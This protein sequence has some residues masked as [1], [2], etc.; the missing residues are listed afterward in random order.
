MR[1]LIM[2]FLLLTGLALALEPAPNPDK[3]ASVE[4]ALTYLSPPFPM[5]KALKEALSGRKHSEAATLLAAVDKSKIPG[6]AVGDHGFLMAW[7]LLRAGKA[8]EA[9]KYTA[10]VEKAEHAPP[11]YKALTLAELYSA[12]GR[13]VE[14]AKALETFPADA[15]LWP[16]A[17]LARASALRYAGNTA[18]SRALYEQL[19]ARPDPSEG[20][21]WALLNLAQQAGKGSPAAYPLYRRIWAYYPTTEAGKQAETALKEYPT[22]ATWQESAVRGDRLMVANNFQGAVTLLQPLLPKV[23]AP[24]AD[25]CRLWYAYGRSLFKLNRLT[26]AADVLGP[27]GVKCKGFDDDRGAK[28]LYIAGKAQERKKAW[29]EAARLFAEIPKLYPT[30]SYADDGY[31]L[32]GIGLQEAGDPEAARTLW[33]EGVKKV[34][35]GDLAAES[36]WRLA[37]GAY[38]AGKTD[39]AIQWAEKGAWEVPITADATHVQACLYWAARWRAWPD[40]NAPHTLTTDPKRKEEAARLLQRFVEQHP[41]NWYT[42]LAAARLKELDPGA[43]AKLPDPPKGK[44]TPWVVREEFLKDPHIAAGLALAQLGLTREALAEL[45]RLDEGA[46]TPAEF[47]LIT[48]IQWDQGDI[49]FAHERLRSYIDTHPPEVMGAQR[50]RV[51]VQAYPE[52]YWDEVK[53]AAKEYGW[54][55]RM[56]HALVREE[57]SFN[58]EIV[59]H[60]GARGLSQLMPATARTVAGWLSM[61]VT[62]A[63]L[64]DP[65]INTKIGARYMQF[66]MLRYGG[67]PALSMAGYNAG[68]GNVDKWLREKGNLPTDEFVESI[69]FRETRGYVKRVSRTWVTYHHLYDDGPVL[70]DLSAYNHKAKP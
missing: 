65:A 51:L 27:A 12:D 63:Q 23:T 6:H 47:A 30:H 18:A 28:A 44:K 41:H 70:P 43:W 20:S 13:H 62:T 42:L 46:Y 21:E 67:N 68:E 5:D 11:T 1:R 16:R 7:S 48:S 8:S 34:P 10:M 26:E 61:S 25:A 59:S 57:S 45:T 24:S 36:F 37:W 15:Q 49:L 66:L 9:V 17:M 2:P 32:G 54:D 56:F 55:P 35:D 33:A 69:P 29:A 19:A 31:A 3:P 50:D 22:A 60:A 64:N 52:L 40:V 53:A 58:K 38:R 14:A 39:E 4:L